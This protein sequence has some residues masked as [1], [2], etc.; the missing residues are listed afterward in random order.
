MKAILLS[1]AVLLAFS[2]CAGD[3]ALRDDSF[4]TQ[5]DEGRYATAHGDAVLRYVRDGGSESERW[6]RMS[7]ALMFLRRIEAAKDADAITAMAR[8]A[9]LPGFWKRYEQDHL[10][11]ERDCNVN[12]DLKAELIRSGF[13]RA[14][15]E[16][17]LE[18]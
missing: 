3:R 17:E 6:E 10:W 16:L 14:L 1:V 11:A 9:D 12:P 15:R 2:A 13:R 5:S 8:E 7:G 4:S 18:R